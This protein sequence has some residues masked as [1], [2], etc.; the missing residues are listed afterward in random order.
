MLSIAPAPVIFMNT[1]ADDMR[2]SFT[3]RRGINRGVFGDE[4]ADGPTTT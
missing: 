1:D 3:G 4:H 2:K